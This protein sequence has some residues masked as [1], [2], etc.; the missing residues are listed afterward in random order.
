MRRKVTVIGAGNVGANVAQK[1]A[2]KEPLTIRIRHGVVIVLSMWVMM[3]DDQSRVSRIFAGGEALVSSGRLRED[4][5]FRKQF[6]TITRLSRLPHE[7][8]PKT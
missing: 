1:I 4:R 7:H 8:I 3:F 6:V 2:L 5:A